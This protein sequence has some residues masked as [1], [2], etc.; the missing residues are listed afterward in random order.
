MT[1]PSPIWHPFTQHGLGDPIPLIARAE[2]ARLYDAE[3]SELQ[4]FAVT[5]AWE[6]PKGHGGVS[7]A[8][9][10][11]E[12]AAAQMIWISDPAA[13]KVHAVDLFSNTVKSVDVAGAP[14]SLVV[15]NAG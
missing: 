3:G 15:A 8:I 11:G 1:T 9:F 5:G 4:T 14:S 13:N 6:L 2:G 10:G 12:Q 7:P